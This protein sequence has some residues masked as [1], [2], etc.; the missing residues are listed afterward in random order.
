MLR[1]SLL[2]AAFFLSSPAF[3]TP[4]IIAPAEPMVTIKGLESYGPSRLSTVLHCLS[5][6]N[7]E[8]ELITDEQLETTE[9]CLE[10]HT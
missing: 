3:C 7:A 1:A 10:E 6:A 2:S 5:I 9:Q 4:L 8:Q